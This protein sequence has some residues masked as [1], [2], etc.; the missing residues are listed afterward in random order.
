MTTYK[1]MTSLLLGYDNLLLTAHHDPDADC[2]GSMLG[3]YHLWG[4][5]QLGWVMTLED[6]VPP[7]LNYLPGVKDILHPAD[8]PV[9][10]RAV[11]FLDCG[12][13]SRVSRGWLDAY[14]DLP[15]YCIDHHVSNEFMGEM[16]VV[17]QDAS[18]TG[19]IVAAMGEA[20]N[21]PLTIEAALCLYSAIIS[22]TGCFRYE[23]T[24]PRAMEIAA[25]LLRF[26]VDLEQVRIRL[27]ES[28]TPSGIAVL[29]AAFSNMQFTA[30]G[31][32][33]YSFVRFEEAQAAN[34]AMA[35]FHN[36]ANYTLL[37]AGVI[38]GLFFEEYSDYVKVSL[39]SRHGLRMDQLAQTLGG[40]GHMRAAGCR[41]NGGLDAALPRVLDA[42]LKIMQ[43]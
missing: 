2:I 7:N 21:L 28:R 4:G 18:S 37:R 16:A 41:L 10:P 35:D 13:P 30:D 34:A 9:Q 33:C 25:R 12:E 23:N 43:N 31:K 36:I 20:A 40:G 29:Q 3:L 19:E 8:V 38:I 11:L 42:A 14:K 27:F 39:R 1:Q 22:D 15:F 5:K 32:I 24:T 6:K 26:G 17:E